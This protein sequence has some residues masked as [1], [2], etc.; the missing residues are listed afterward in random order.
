MKSLIKIILYL[1]T[2]FA[3]TF[4]LLKL[5]GLLTVEHIESY[6]TQARELSLI[7]VG[8]LV[9]ILLHDYAPCSCFIAL[10]T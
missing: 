5:T 2:F 9:A 7:Y 8:S 4:L 1:A 6:L 3:S 10:T